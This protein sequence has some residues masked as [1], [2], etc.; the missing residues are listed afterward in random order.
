MVGVFLCQAG[1]ARSG[2][3]ATVERHVAVREWS[4][5][6]SVASQPDWMCL[7]AHGDFTLA[8]RI[9]GSRVLHDQLLLWH[10]GKIGRKRR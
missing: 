10:G 2:C 5:E 8:L 9:L 7:L 6:C 1:K 4:V 3:N